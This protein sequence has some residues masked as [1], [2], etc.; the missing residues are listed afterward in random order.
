MG[1]FTGS[2]ARRSL[3]P[4]SPARSLPQWCEEMPGT[5]QF[6]RT[7]ASC[8]RRIFQLRGRTSSTSSANGGAGASDAD[9]RLSQARDQ[10]DRPIEARWNQGAYQVVIS[11]ALTRPTEAI[12]FL[13]VFVFAE[14]RAADHR[15]TRMTHS[16]GSSLQDGGALRAKQ[17]KEHRQVIIV[18]LQPTHRGSRM[19]SDHPVEAG[20]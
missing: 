17:P 18:D 13:T 7:H 14:P 1:K 12:D 8:N 4:R 10:G 6:E 3:P 19:P 5:E 9:S 2:R 11:Q 16:T 15:S 20:V